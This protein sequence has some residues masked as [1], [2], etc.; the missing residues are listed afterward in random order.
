MA[1]EIPKRVRVTSY[2]KNLQKKYG[3]DD[4]SNRMRNQWNMETVLEDIDNDTH[5][6]QL[7][8]FYFLYS[9]TRTFK[10]FFDKYHEYYEAMLRVKADR[11][12][13]AALRKQ[14]VE[15]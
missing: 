10:E 4:I 11:V 6:K 5:V 1:S 14:T 7:I 12:A 15:G 3:V 13:R 8:Q 2:F 9:D